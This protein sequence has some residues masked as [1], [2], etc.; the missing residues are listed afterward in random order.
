MPHAPSE[1]SALL[2]QNEKER[3]ST[4]FSSP[5]LRE[6][7]KRTGVSTVIKDYPVLDFPAKIK[8]K[9]G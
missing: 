5:K 1:Y 7:N 4:K 3:K 2:E 9:E 8:W 6:V